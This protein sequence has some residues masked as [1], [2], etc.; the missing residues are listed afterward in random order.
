MGTM[1]YIGL[2]VS[3]SSGHHVSYGIGASS[4]CY[5]H[6]INICG[7]FDPV[8]VMSTIDGLLFHPVVLM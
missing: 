3:F 2:H 8:A 4:S 1:S 6:M 7:T 5:A